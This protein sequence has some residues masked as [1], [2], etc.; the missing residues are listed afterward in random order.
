MFSNELT[1]YAIQH[2]YVSKYSLLP[3]TPDSS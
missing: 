1:L 3:D 2:A